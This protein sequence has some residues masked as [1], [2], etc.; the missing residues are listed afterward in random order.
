MKKLLLATTALL[1][2]Y[3][4]ASDSFDKELVFVGNQELANFCKAVAKDD[5]SLLRRS[6][7][8]KVGVFATSKAGVYELLLNEENLSCNGK[9]IKEFSKE[10]NADQVLSYLQTVEQGI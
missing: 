1:S 9:G 7:S 4:S 3:A 10:R 8:N 5:V 6:F 2:C